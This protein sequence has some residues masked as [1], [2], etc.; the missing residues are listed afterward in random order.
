MFAAVVDVIFVVAA[1]P[2]GLIHFELLLLLTPAV[3]DF[4][5]KVDI[6]GSEYV[7]FDQAVEGAFTDHEGIPV[8]GTDMV[9]GLSL[10]DEGGN[11]L[12]Q[13]LDFCL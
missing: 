2:A 8:V 12:I 5:G 10:E 4:S 7:V 3:P 11:N 13:T 1:N 9:E 6:S